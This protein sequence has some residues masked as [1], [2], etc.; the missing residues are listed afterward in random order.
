MFECY[1]KDSCGLCKNNKHC[2][3]RFNIYED[4]SSEKCI[5]YNNILSENDKEY[6]SIIKD[7]EDNDV[8][9]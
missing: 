9:S 2:K 8:N 6:K 1:W 5:Y 7:M 3:Y 4:D